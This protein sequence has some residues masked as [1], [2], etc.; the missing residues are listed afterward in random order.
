MTT[1]NR[2]SKICNPV[3]VNFQTLRDGRQD[4][5]NKLVYDAIMSDDTKTFDN[6]INSNQFNKILLELQK[7]RFDFLEEI[8]ENVLACRLLAMNIS[9]KASRQGT[10]DEKTQITTCDTT[11]RQFGITIENL[12]ANSA[13]PLKQGGIITNQQFKQ[14]KIAKN[15]CLKSFDGR[16][17]GNIT[18]WIFA[19]VVYGNGGHQDNVFQETHDFCDWVI[20]YGKIENPNDKFVVLID[21]DLQQKFNECKKKYENISN[22]LIEN[23][24]TF[25]QYIINTY[26]SN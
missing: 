7:T 16:I 25:Q 23:H 21:T 18:G 24:I 26:S 12:P 13:R 5:N 17:T 8:K 3:R 19:K 2:L 1:L 10:K 15:D 20:N 9:K 11:S 4:T 22:L 14:Q 6:N